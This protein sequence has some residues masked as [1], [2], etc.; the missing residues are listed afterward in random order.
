[1]PHWRPLWPYARLEDATQAAR[2][3][4]LGDE[5]AKSIETVADRGRRE[6]D[7]NDHRGHD[8]GGAQSF[9]E[10]GTMRPDQPRRGS[11]WNCEDDPVRRKDVSASKSQPPLAILPIDL[12]DVGLRAN[13]AGKRSA[14][15]QGNGLH[16]GPGRRQYRG[17]PT[18]SLGREHPA[19]KPAMGSLESGDPRKSRREGQPLCV[20]GPHTQHERRD[21]CLGRLDAQT[22]AAKFGDRFF[23]ARRLARE[24]LDEHPQPTAPRQEIRGEQRR[25]RH[26]HLAQSAAAKYPAAPGGRSGRHKVNAELPAQCG[27]PGL[28]AGQKAVGRVLA[29]IA[30]LDLRAKHP[31]QPVTGFED[32]QVGARLTLADPMTRGQAGNARADDRDPWRHRSGN[33]AVLVHR[34][35][36][37]T[38]MLRIRWWQDPVPEVE[39]EARA[40]RSRRD[41][42]LHP[43]F[44][45][46]R[47]REERGRIKVSLN[48]E[49][50][51]PAAR[52]GHVHPANRAR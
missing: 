1:M 3:L 21:Q 8:L 10:R 11:G 50:S 42:L 16:A 37:R 33:R 34:G 27:R 17:L 19:E 5:E 41:D 25:G 6:A 23:P 35:D 44:D 32:G 47:W 26:G 48:G 13:G 46:C 31:T 36:H 28:R 22:P 52:G 24:R 30:A 39:H 18:S 20:P 15:G 2:R 38:N 45:E 9:G 29:Q 4:P 14:E 51:Q 43:L 7:M 12:F 40:D 49:L